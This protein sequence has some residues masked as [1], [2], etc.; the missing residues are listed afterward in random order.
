LELAS[1]GPSAA[2]EPAFQSQPPEPD[3][4]V[5]LFFRHASYPPP[6]GFE[7]QPENGLALAYPPTQ[8]WI[9]VP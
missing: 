3:A 1:D 6:K 7:R 9:F 8:S 5:M 4:A 2:A